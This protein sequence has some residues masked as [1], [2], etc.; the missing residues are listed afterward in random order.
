MRFGLENHMS[1]RDATEVSFVA[2]SQEDEPLLRFS[3]P[4]IA[5]GVL[6]VVGLWGAN[7]S[8]KTKLLEAF[9]IFRDLIKYSFS[10]WEPHSPLPWQPFAMHTGEDA[11]PTRMDMDFIIDGI[12]HHY[13]MA[14]TANG[15][16]EEWLYHWPKNYRKVIFHR[17]HREEDPWYFGPSFR[18]QKQSIVKATRGNSLF[19]SCAAQFNHEK[20]TR[21]YSA[22]AEGITMEQ[23]IMLRGYPLFQSDSVLVQPESRSMVLRFLA[24][25][26]IGVVDIDI[27]EHE[28]RPSEGLD[29]ILKPDVLERIRAR[30]KKQ[31]TLFEI[32]L[33]H[34]DPLGSRWTLHPQDESG[35]TSVLLRRL[36]DILGSLKTGGP[37]VFDEID[38]SLHPELGALL[39]RLFTD[40]QINRNQA[41]LIFSTHNRSLMSALRRDEVL[42]L[43]KARDGS[44]SLRAASDYAGLRGRDD[45]RRA[46]EQG[47]VRGVPVLGNLE[48]VVAEGLDGQPRP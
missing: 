43:D 16:V 44:S 27:K 35:G 11:P 5:H 18:G 26:D 47:R 28:V 21:I 3:A 7:A 30:E 37:V 9:Q 24:A 34:G 6:P 12:R 8:G 20:L 29:E 39:I 46:Y 25:A 42:L 38:V 13:G 22:I 17:N 45:L 15:F 48:E 1:F 32:H 36:E 10:G 19:L 33:V 2:T 41:Q 14:F 40:G 23:M 4:Q 31:D